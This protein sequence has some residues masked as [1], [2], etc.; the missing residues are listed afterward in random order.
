MQR[1]KNNNNN[2]SLIKRV[3]IPSRDA[4]ISSTQRLR[5]FSSKNNSS[6]NAA[7]SCKA[8]AALTCESLLELG[9][10]RHVHGA[11][12]VAVEQRRVGPVTQQQRADLH[13][14]FGRRLVERGELPQVHG[15]HTR[16]VL[17]REDSECWINKKAGKHGGREKKQMVSSQGGNLLFEFISK[18]VLKKLCKQRRFLLSALTLPNPHRAIG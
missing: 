3:E 14:V 13:P 10:G 8:G 2:S 12:A 17:G 7:R 16:P 9:S 15:V 1:L 11:L 18:L 6:I 5:P 4:P